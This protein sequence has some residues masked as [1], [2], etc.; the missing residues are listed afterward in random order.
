MVQRTLGPTG[1]DRIYISHDEMWDTYDTQLTNVTVNPDP[2]APG[3]SYTET[4][5]VSLPSSAL[6]GEKYILIITDGDNQQSET[7]E[8]N[9]LLAVPITVTAPNLTVT[10]V[11]GPT[12]AALG[13]IVR[14]EYTVTNEGSVPAAADW[15]DVIHLS[16]DTRPGNDNYLDDYST[17]DA[18]RPIA[19]GESYQ[20]ADVEMS[21][22]VGA[23]D[24]CWSPPTGMTISRKRTNKTTSAPWRS[25][26]PRRI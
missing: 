16:A 23:I 1:A 26:L 18:G 25:R 17:M 14:V 19:P 10:D 22:P 15:D 20:Y 21:V 9:N 5:T 2:L 24:T 6:P 11:V 13:E 3:G 7:N 12:T 4:T 8:D